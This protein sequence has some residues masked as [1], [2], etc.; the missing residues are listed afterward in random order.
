MG[1]LVTSTANSAYG[2]ALL[3]AATTGMAAAS[4]TAPRTVASATSLRLLS[5]NRRIVSSFRRSIAPVKVEW[6]PNA[7]ITTG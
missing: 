5:V 3:A 6:G 2:P 7:K 1:P 4:K